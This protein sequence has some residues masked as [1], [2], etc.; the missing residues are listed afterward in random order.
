MSSKTIPGETSSFTVA[1]DSTER[2]VATCAAIADTFVLRAKG[3][4][5]RSALGAGEG[6]W[7]VPCES[8]HTIGMRF[9]I[10]LLYLDRKCRVVQFRRAM[11]PWRVSACLTARSV[12]EL[13]AGAID[14]ARVAL[15]DTLIFTPSLGRSGDSPI[16]ASPTHTNKTDRSGSPYIEVKNTVSSYYAACASRFYVQPLL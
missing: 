10:D 3:L 5:G 4:L 13:P 15:G 11:S 6:L 1:I 2:V 9:S 16:P 8:V 7:I 12:L 14:S